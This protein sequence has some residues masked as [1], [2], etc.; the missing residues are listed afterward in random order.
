VQVYHLLRELRRFSRWRAADRL[1]AR[2]AG[3]DAHGGGR[4]KSMDHGGTTVQMDEIP[5]ASV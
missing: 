2:R 4:A 5:D 1:C 3:G